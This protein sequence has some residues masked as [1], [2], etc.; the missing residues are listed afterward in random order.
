M[1]ELGIEVKYLAYPRAGVGSKSY[2]KVASAWCAEDKN[3]ALTQLKNGHSIEENICEGNPVASQFQ[4]G[5]QLGVRGTPAI[6][7]ESGEMIPGYIPAKE[8]AKKLG[9]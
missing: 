7:L 3:Q 9:I 4:L 8:L 2:N 5:G 6:L 1:N